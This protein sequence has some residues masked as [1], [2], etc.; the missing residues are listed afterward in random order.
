MKTAFQLIRYRREHGGYEKEIQGPWIFETIED[1][2]AKI[3][4]LVHFGQVE[5]LTIEH[6]DVND[7]SAFE[8]EGRNAARRRRPKPS[9]A[10]LHRSNR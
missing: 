4:E 8:P 1:A 6:V 3:D 10:S 5:E 7:D 9:P 2:Q